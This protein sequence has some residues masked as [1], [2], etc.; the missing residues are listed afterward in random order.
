MPQPQVV[1]GDQLVVPVQTTPGV[2]RAEAFASDQVW[3]GR[4]QNEAGQMSGWH[5]H[6]GHDTYGYCVSGRFVVEFGAAGGQSIE[7]GPGDYVLIRRGVVH[8]EGNRSPDPN[9]G[10]IVRVG[11]GPVVVNLDGPEPRLDADSA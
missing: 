2:L 6:P 11:E 3:V 7:A 8:R 5:V 9:E 1:R 4:V 10:V